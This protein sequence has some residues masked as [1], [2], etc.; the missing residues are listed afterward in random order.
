LLFGVELGGGESKDLRL[1][2]LPFAPGFKDTHIEK[3]CPPRGFSFAVSINH[4]LLPGPH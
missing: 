3:P 2:I 1:G 4:C